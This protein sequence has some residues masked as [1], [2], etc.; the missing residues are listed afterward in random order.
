MKTELAVSQPSRLVL[1]RDFR[2]SVAHSVGILGN[3]VASLILYHAQ[4]S[5]DVDL[6]QLPQGVERF[7]RALRDLLGSSAIV[8]VRECAKRLSAVLGMRIE[9]LPDSLTLLYR[10]VA[11]GYRQENRFSFSELTPR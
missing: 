9:P 5:F 8:V 2:E 6:S 3:S 1:A 11:E 4:R 10:R 7:D